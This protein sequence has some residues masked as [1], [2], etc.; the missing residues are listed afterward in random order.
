MSIKLNNDKIKKEDID[1]LCEWLYTEPRLT[2]DKLCKEF[3]EEF[4]KYT[5]SNY[6]VFVNSGS[7]ANLLALAY[8]ARK[9]GAKGRNIV[10]PAVSWATDFAPVIQ[11][12]FNPVLVDCNL[13]DY[14]SSLEDLEHL[15]S[16]VSPLAYIHVSVLGYPGNLFQ[17]KSLCEK[18]NVI[19]IE[20]NCESLG[21]EFKGKKIGFAGLISTYSFYYSHHISTIEGGM[22]CTNDVYV[23]NILRMLREHGWARNCDN[24]FQKGLGHKYED[25][26]KFYEYG[27]NVRNTEIAAFLGLS[28]LK[29]FKEEK[30]SITGSFDNLS[31]EVEVRHENLRRFGGYIPS[32]CLISSFGI[33]VLVQSLEEA[34]IKLHRHSVEYRPIIAGSMEFQPMVKN[35]R[36]CPNAKI[37]HEHGIYLPN[38]TGVGQKEILHYQEAVRGNLWSA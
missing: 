18:Y 15:F 7:S 19:L 17:I 11:L 16:S 27:F 12:G 33:P 4:A 9:H 13:D 37:V 36:K 35:G 26:F 34:G 23:Y 32:D 38:H 24:W 21:T 8:L 20:D 2:Q 28:Q 5:E 6:A 1:K 10:V 3:E 25:K 30:Y 31:S 29:K 14:T 22:V